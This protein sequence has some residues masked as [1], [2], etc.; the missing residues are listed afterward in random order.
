MGGST[1]PD[2]PKL[3][4][5]DDMFIVW[6]IGDNVAYLVTAHSMRQL[7]WEEYQ[8][9]KVAW[10]DIPEHSAYPET[11]QTLMCAVHAQAKT[12]IEDLRALG[13]SI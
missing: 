9:Y 7:T 5:G 13:G 6:R 4:I 11:V 1:Q 12:M 8:A 2:E 3:P 10:P